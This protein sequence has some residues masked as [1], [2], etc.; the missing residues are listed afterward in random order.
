M[1]IYK[2]IKLDINTKINEGIYKSGEKIPSERVMSTLYGVSR[3]TI[4]Q[5]LLELEN[6]GIIHREKGRGAFVSIQELYQ[7][8]LKS[9]TQ[10][11]IEQGM[12]PTTRV[13][14]VSTVSKLGAISKVLDVHEGTS[15]YK[16][17]R[18]RLGD[19]VPIALEKIYIPTQYVENILGYNMKGSLYKVL[20]DYYG[21][22]VTHIDCTIEAVISNRGHIRVLELKKPTALLKVFGVTFAQDNLKLFYEESYYR[23]DLYKYHVDIMRRP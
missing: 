10:T 20:E 21:Y 16:I 11:L 18:L 6:E 7:D 5:A 12:V 19:D 17:K 8:N 4:R 1:S 9:F 13:I 3:M 15:Y 23:S 2:N 14:E 22:D